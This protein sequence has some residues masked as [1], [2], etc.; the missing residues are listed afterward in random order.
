MDIEGIFSLCG[1]ITMIGWLLL[2]ISP[3]VSPAKKII[4]WGIIPFLVSLV[5]A[6]IFLTQMGDGE[7]G[8]DT[9][10]NVK[11]LFQNDY[12]LLAGWIHYLAFDLWLGCWA[13]FDSKK[14]GI[15]H[16]V[17]IPVLF[18]F[19]MAGPFALMIYFLVRFV[20][21]KTPLHENF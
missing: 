16:L 4:Q 12:A 15:H 14:Y 20:Y 8:F 21:T 1:G 6:W 2:V 9:F 17:M 19:L 5:Y 13:L 3:I 11:L 7:G 10:A 18:G